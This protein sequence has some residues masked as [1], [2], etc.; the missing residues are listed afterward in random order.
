MLQEEHTLMIPRSGTISDLTQALQ[1]KC[2]ISDETMDK[3]QVYAGHNNKWYRGYSPDLQVH[4]IGD[5]LQVYAA[6][7]PEDDSEKKITVF[8]FDKEPKNVHGHPFQF[9][10]KEVCDHL[11]L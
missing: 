1:K 10:V 9:P 11:N 7:F 3:I 4:G 8:H 6:V 5:F 2:N